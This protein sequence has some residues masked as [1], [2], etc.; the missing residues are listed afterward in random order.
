LELKNKSVDSS[1]HNLTNLPGIVKSLEKTQS[2]I[3][4][5]DSPVKNQNTRFTRFE[6][7]LINGSRSSSIDKAIDYKIIS[8]TGRKDVAAETDKIG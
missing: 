2:T 7:L 4:K 6:K 5:Q 8:M 1:A 3:I